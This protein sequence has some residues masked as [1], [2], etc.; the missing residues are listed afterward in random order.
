[1]SIENAFWAVTIMQ[2]IR[3]HPKFFPNI[4]KKG[5]HKT[6]AFATEDVHWAY[7]LLRYA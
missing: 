6:S 2:L 4:K 3:A 7:Q 1:M 5:S